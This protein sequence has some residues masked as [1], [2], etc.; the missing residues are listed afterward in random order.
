MKMSLGNRSRCIN[1]ATAPPAEPSYDGFEAG[2]TQL[3]ERM[4]ILLY[5]LAPRLFELVDF[6]NDETFLEP[7]LFAYT[8]DP[9]PMVKLDQILFGYIAEHSRP[10][11]ILVYADRRGIVELPRIGY[12]RTD[13]KSRELRL[14]WKGGVK[15]CILIDGI[16]VLNH[17]YEMPI[18]VEDTSI[19]I[20]RYNHPLLEKFFVDEDG[21]TV[22]VDGEHITRRQASNLS[23]ALQIIRQYIPDYYEMILKVT[24]KIVVYSSERPF[25][26]ATLSAHGIAFLNASEN[27]DE[28]F[29][30]EDLIHQCGHVIFSALT[31]DP[32]EVLRIA[33]NTPLKQ[34]TGDGRDT[35]NIYSTLHGVFTETWMNRCMD[36]C[37]DSGVF[38]QRQRHELLGRFALI[39]TRFGCD[40]RN[41]TVDHIF[42]W[43]GQLFLKW[44]ARV[45]R[46]IVANRYD[47]LSQFD[48]SNQPYCFS[49]ERF[50]TSNPPSEEG[51]S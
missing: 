30:I 35:R 3:A 20:S 50:L 40:L 41:L 36:L 15:N 26:F 39:L 10:S 18:V 12:L 38:S 33:P 34:L 19:E 43:Q 5:K 17:G 27:D 28:V 24:R 25:S 16:S 47:L 46:E 22:D 6:S 32:Q 11:E 7:L 1:A 2:Q 48:I 45:Y 49:Y 4:R 29:F 14:V 51:T 8:V 13:V 31:L 37:C 21:K 9:K 42:T 23:K 44:F